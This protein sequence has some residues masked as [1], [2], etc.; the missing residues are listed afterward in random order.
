[1][2]RPRTVTFPPDE[3]ILL[4]DEMISWIKENDP[5]HLSEWYTIEKGFTYSQWKSMIVREEFIP[6]YEKALKL[7]GRKYLNGDVNPSIAQR[8]QRVYFNDIRERED[9]DLDA[10][11]ARSKDNDKKVDPAYEQAFNAMLAMLRGQQ[12][13]SSERN[14]AD[15]NK[16]TDDRS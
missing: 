16:S 11:A 3:M 13:Q 5:F 2:V 9:A 7:V 15:N 8:W 6:Y 10:A 1:M 4:G 12:I 14:I